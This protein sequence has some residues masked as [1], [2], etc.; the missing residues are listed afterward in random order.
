MKRIIFFCFLLL[1]FLATIGQSTVTATAGKWRFNWLKVDS[2]YMPT[3]TTAQRPLASGGPGIYFNTD[4]S[5]IQYSN[6]TFWSTLGTSTGGSPNLPVGGNFNIAIAGTNN[7][8]SIGQRYGLV[9]DSITSNNLYFTVDT[10][11]VTGL[12]TNYWRQKGVDSLSSIISTGLAGK[13][14]TLVSGTNLKTINGISLLGSGDLATVGGTGVSDT[15][16]LARKNNNLSDLGSISQAKINLGIDLVANIT[17]ATRNAATASFTNK[18]LATGSNHITGTTGKAAQFNASTGDLENSAT[19]TTELGYVSGVTSAIQTQINSKVPSIRKLTINGVDYDFSADRVITVGTGAPNTS[20]GAGYRV[21]INGT[22]NVKDLQPKYGI[23]IDSATANNVGIKADTATLFPAVRATITAGTDSAAN[24]GYGINKS[25]VGTTRVYKLDTSVAFPAV[26]ATIPAFDSTSLKSQILLRVNI[27]DTANMLTKYLRKIDTSGKWLPIGTLVGTDSAANAGYG[28]S[29]S[30]AGTTRVLRADT[31]VLF[32]ALRATVPGTA[33]SAGGDLSGSFPNPTL[34]T[35][36]VVPGSYTN[37]NLTVDSKGR[38]Q[39]ISNGTAGS[40]GTVANGKWR[41]AVDAAT[42]VLNVDTPYWN[43]NLTAD[44]AISFLNVHEGSP[45]QIMITHTVPGTVISAGLGDLPWGYAFATGTNERTSI[46]GIYDSAAARWNWTF[47]IFPAIAGTLRSVHQMAAYLK[48]TPNMYTYYSNEKSI[49]ID[50]FWLHA[51]N[52]DSVLSNSYRATIKKAADTIA[53]VGGITFSPGLSGNMSVKEH[54]QMVIDLYN[55]PALYRYNGM[56][57]IMIYN[58]DSTKLLRM[59]DSLTANGIARSSYKIMVSSTVYP[60]WQPW[61]T[62][63]RWVNNVGSPDDSASVAQLYVFNPQ[64]DGIINFSGDKATSVDSIAKNK[65]INENLW[66]TQA[67]NALGKLSYVGYTISYHND[68]V[69]NWDIGLRGGDSVLMA[70]V[71]KPKNARATFVGAS[72]DNDQ[73]EET[74]AGYPFTPITNGLFYQPTLESSS[75]EATGAYPSLNHNGIL[76]LFR[77]HLEALRYGLDNVQVPAVDQIVAKYGLHPRGATPSNVIPAFLVPYKNPDS[78]KITQAKW[79]LSRAANA[80]AWVA[81]GRMP[82][83]DRIEMAAWLTDDAYLVINGNISPTLYSRGLAFYSIPMPT[84]GLP[85]TP[86]FAIRRGGVNV[87]TVSGNQAITA[88]TWP[89]Q[90]DSLIEH[91][92]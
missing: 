62:P 52:Y 41:T 43:I 57:V 74:H 12:S 87:I 72:T 21:A 17:E 56:P 91:L 11:H 68:I 50:H 37:A 6:G 53:M 45:I 34:T 75:Y 69:Q 79:N 26:R 19:T 36:S 63:A 8:K 1:S 54:K 14:A 15:T 7:V 35:T 16:A 13:Q 89:G 64:V 47:D 76:K 22:N 40:G 71:R 31:S 33:G 28:L 66:I 92:Y 39:A 61:L 85:I 73:N 10:N 2:L 42:I 88:S 3:G 44:R 81:S 58:F 67:S 59:I 23:T 5:K 24:A 83:Y 30:N 25:N 32:P 4:S 48:L 82:L 29:K 90:Y 9:L 77:P 46:K 80:P 78:L 86:T 65:N 84:T 27:S 18:T 49:G 38:V 20:A 55:H 60:Q 70:E 51:D